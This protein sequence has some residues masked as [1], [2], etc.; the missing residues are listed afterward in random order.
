MGRADLPPSS[1]AQL[2]PGFA[3]RDNRNYGSVCV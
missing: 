3:L 1:A 2:V